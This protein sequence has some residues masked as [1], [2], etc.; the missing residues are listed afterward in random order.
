MKFVFKETTFLFM[1]EFL[2]AKF[3]F[4]IDSSDVIF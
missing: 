2:L 4:G 3:F 1:Y